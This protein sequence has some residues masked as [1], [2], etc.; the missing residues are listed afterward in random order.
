MNIDVTARP[1]C[2]EGCPRPAAPGDPYCEA[3]SIERALFRRDERFSGGREEKR[4]VEF[5]GR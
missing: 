2:N 3:C 5:P 4:T 1:C